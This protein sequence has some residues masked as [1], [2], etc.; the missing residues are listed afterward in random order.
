MYMHISVYGY[1]YAYQISSLPFSGLH[2]QVCLQETAYG[3]VC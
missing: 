3:K 2:S 1:P